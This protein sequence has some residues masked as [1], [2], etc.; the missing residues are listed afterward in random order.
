[1]PRAAKK[2]PAIFHLRDHVII[3]HSAGMEGEI[4]ELRDPLGPGGVAVYRVMLQPEPDYE[5]IEVLGDQL[6]LVTDGTPSVVP[7]PPRRFA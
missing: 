5:Y 7:K 1:M 2:A 4:I 3:K 6:E